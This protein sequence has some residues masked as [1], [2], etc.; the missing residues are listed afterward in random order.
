[1]LKYLRTCVKHREATCAKH[2]ESE[3]FLPYKL[4]QQLTS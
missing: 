4:N 1:M 3:V 2:R